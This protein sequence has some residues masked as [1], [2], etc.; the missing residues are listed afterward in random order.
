[1]HLPTLCLKSASQRGFSEA[2]TGFASSPLAR[3]VDV[4]ANPRAI[5]HDD[6]RTVAGMGSSTMRDACCRRHAGRMT[7][8]N[9]ML[10]VVNSDVKVDLNLSQG[11][12]FA[13]AWIRLAGELSGVPSAA[14]T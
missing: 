7:E 4:D 2:V 12:L 5:G 3:F 6:G 9:R 8:N 13:W 11:F 1:M 14:V 10:Q